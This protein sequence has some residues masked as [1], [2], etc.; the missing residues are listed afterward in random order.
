MAERDGFQLPLSDF[1]TTLGSGVRQGAQYLRENPTAPLEWGYDMY[2]RARGP[3]LTGM[4]REGIETGYGLAEQGLSGVQG[5]LNRTGLGVEFPEVAGGGRSPIPNISVGHQGIERPPQAA[6]PAPP[7]APTPP[8]PSAERGDE[9]FEYRSPQDLGPMD[10]R[11]YEPDRLPEMGRE[12]ERAGMEQEEAALADPATDYGRDPAPPI[13]WEEGVP[14]RAETGGPSTGAVAEAE[15][16]GPSTWDK[17]AQVLGNQGVQRGLADLHR[18]TKRPDASR[19]YARMGFDKQTRD[20]EQD[21]QKQD[22]LDQQEAVKRAELESRERMAGEEISS[23]ERMAQMDRDARSEQFDRQY[24]QPI[25]PELAA[26]LG[27]DAAAWVGRPVDEYRQ[28]KGEQRMQASSEA[29]SAYQMMIGMAQLDKRNK[30]FEAL[31][32][33]MKNPFAMRFLAETD[34]QKYAEAQRVLRENGWPTLPDAEG[35]AAP[36]GAEGGTAP[37]DPRRGVFGQLWDWVL[38]GIGISA[39]AMGQTGGA[40]PAAGMSDLADPTGPQIP[41]GAQAQTL[42]SQGGAADQT[43]PSQGPLAGLPVRAQEL[44]GEAF[45]KYKDDPD[46]LRQA[47]NLIIE[48]APPEDKERVMRILAQHIARI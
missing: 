21:R 40:P 7:T 44:A 5:A 8:Q 14:A 11:G 28:W 34:P 6:Q 45:R 4:V 24:G 2:R 13:D 32:M 22:A 18:S 43:L 26:A 36:P 20:I 10:P 37:D 39:P 16:G 47:L 38:E 19:A 31:D 25:T 41:S 35:L 23:R 48:K 27:P 9:M 42:S 29:T 30:A 1:A 15:E 3:S 46:G 17:I 33:I 12:I